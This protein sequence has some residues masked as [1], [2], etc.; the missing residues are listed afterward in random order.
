MREQEKVIENIIERER[1]RES[2]I[3][4][5]ERKSIREKTERKRASEREKKRMK[6]RAS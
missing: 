1:E 6:E 3:E 4:K 5:T 2:I